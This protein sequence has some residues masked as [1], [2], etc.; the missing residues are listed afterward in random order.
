MGGLFTD[1]V[2]RETLI[3]TLEHAAR[4]RPQTP[5]GLDFAPWNVLTGSVLKRRTGWGGG[6]GD[7]WWSGQEA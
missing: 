1:A 2:A 4:F 7:S 5:D 6:P 3:S